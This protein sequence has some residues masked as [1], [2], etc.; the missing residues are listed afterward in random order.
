MVKGGEESDVCGK[1]RE[2]KEENQEEEEEK[3]ETEMR[4]G[5]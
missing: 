4:G 5:E 2:E 3:K 1:G